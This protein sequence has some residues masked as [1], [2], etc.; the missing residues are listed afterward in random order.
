MTDVI[1]SSTE[2]NGDID[3]EIWIGDSGA[4]C[5]F[6][7]HDDGLYD[8]ADI[9]EEITVG[10][11]NVMLAKKIGKL[12]CGVLQKNGEKLIVTLENV[13]FVPD[14]WINLFSIGKALKNGFNISNNREI[15]SLTKGNVTLTFDNIVRTKDGSVPAI[16]LTPVLNEVGLTVR[17]SEKKE[18]I[19]V[20]NLYKILW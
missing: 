11:G 17:D 14:L 9:S 4:S 7:N 1:L 3:H 19:D 18:S 20:N 12:R 13:K 6:C 5:H 10:N 16:R 8:C 2:N 15:L